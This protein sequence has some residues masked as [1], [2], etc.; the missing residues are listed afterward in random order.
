MNAL[1]NLCDVGLVTAYPPL[2]DI[3][4]ASCK[5]IIRGSSSQTDEHRDHLY[6]ILWLGE[7]LTIFAA[8]GPLSC[9]F[10]LNRFIC[11]TV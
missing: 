11:G 4:G 5:I 2:C 8:A 3:P 10:C 9:I 6:C 7:V 1:K